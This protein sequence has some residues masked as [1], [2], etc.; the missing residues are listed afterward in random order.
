MTP[1]TTFR[2]GIDHFYDGPCGVDYDPHEHAVIL[3]LP[4]V[5]NDRLPDDVVA[6]YSHRHRAVF[7]CPGLPDAVERC[8]LA[9]EI[10]HAE[11]GD[12]GC[13]KLQ[14][15]RAD[16]IAAR[17]LIRTSRVYTRLDLTDDLGAIALDLRVT[18]HMMSTWITHYGRIAA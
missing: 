7:L 5:T 3:D 14:E 17:R 15:R 2:Y 10:V 18:E 12:V 8:A 11:H 4:V 1:S 9:H 16:R 6:A 13:N